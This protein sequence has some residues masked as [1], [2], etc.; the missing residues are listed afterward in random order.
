MVSYCAPPASR[1]APR[2]TARSMLSLGTEFFLAFW[3]ASKS[4]GLPPGSPP[5]VR[6]ATSTFLISRANSLPRLASTTAFLCLV[7]AHFECPD[8]SILRPCRLIHLAR[9]LHEEAVYAKITGQLW[10]E[11]GREQ[12]PLPNRDNPTVL[13]A[14][15]DPAQHGDTGADP[16]HPGRPDEHRVERFR[17]LARG[18]EPVEFDRRLERV[19]LATEGVAPNRHLDAAEA[20]LVR[21][22]VEHLAG[23]HHHARARTV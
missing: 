22:A 5:P 1:P 2:L 9:H 7:V 23:E 3:I 13:P 17:G 12:T 20:D 16:L 14:A 21:P 19:D 10:V 18:A 15:G 6:A 8:I 11:G 4:V